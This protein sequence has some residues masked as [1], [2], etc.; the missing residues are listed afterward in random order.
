MWYVYIVECVDCTLYTGVARDVQA[1]LAQHNSG[2]GAKYTRGRTPVRLVFSEPAPDR[3]AAQQREHAIKRL[4]A[5][6]K[7]ILIAANRP[8]R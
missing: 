8:N 7:R 3:S 4:P 6:D 5:A 1:R 2:A